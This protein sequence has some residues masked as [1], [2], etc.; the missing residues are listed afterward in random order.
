MLNKKVLLSISF[1]FGII[2]TGCS[3]DAQELA[4]QSISEKVQVYFSGV[5]DFTANINSGI[6]EEPYKYNGK[7]GELKDFSIVTLNVGV[8][9]K[10]IQAEIIINDKSSNI[11]LEQDLLTS[12]HVVDL[13]YKVKEED[14]ITIK[15]KEGV[16]DLECRSKNFEINCEQALE[17]GIQTFNEELETLVS[18]KKLSAECYLRIIDNPEDKFNRLFWYFYIYAENGSTHYCVINIADGNVLTKN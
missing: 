10:Y 4:S 3:M 11:L 15:Y 13:G 12:E 1:L 16:V 6:R 17:I 9:E 7:T 14:K 18:K 5:G 2:A 8:D